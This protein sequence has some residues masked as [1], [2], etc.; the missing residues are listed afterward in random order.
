VA[1]VAPHDLA[2]ERSLLGAVLVDNGLLRVAK[3]RP[4][5]FFRVGHGRIWRAYERLSEAGQGIDFVTLRASLEAAGDL[6]EAGGPAYLSGL[7]DG[8]PRASNVEHYAQ[9]VR[10]RAVLRALIAQARVILEEAHHAEDVDEVLG[11]AEAGLL[12]IRPQRTGSLLLAEDWMRSTYRQIE[13]AS[14]EKRRVSGVPT[15][16]GSLDRMTRGLQP[17]HLVFI[18]AR[19]SVGKTSLALQIALEASRHVMTLVVSLEMSPDELGYRAV[20]LE[21]RVDSFRLMTGQVLPHESQRIGEAVSRLGERRLAIQ[22]GDASLHGLCADVRR[23]A[24]QYGLGLLVIDYLQLIDGPKAENRHQEVAAVSKRL[25]RLARELQVPVVA[26]SQLSRDTAQRGGRPQLHHLKESGSQEQDADEVLLLHRPKEHEDGQR[27]ADGEAAEL[28]V[29]KQRNG[30]VGVIPLRWVAALTR[31][32]DVDAV[33]E[34]EPVQ[35]A[36]V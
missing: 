36:L 11:R 17:G 9:I 32:S 1:D 25:K 26:L 2:A 22:D 31:F 28:I 12:A 21:S 4:E 18:G 13:R 8:V 16:L 5:D 20:A 33:H 15:G 19:T 14:V 3:V 30:P 10:E 7:V 24:A 29:A 27:Y 23:V 6:V 34:D 35:E